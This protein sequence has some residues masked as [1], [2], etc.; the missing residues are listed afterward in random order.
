MSGIGKSVMKT[1][2][3]HETLDISDAEKIK[4]RNLSS[5]YTGWVRN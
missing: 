1:S 4:I 3:G 5:C 2:Q